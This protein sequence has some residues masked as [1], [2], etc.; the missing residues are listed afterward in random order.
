MN[1]CVFCE[2]VG[3]MTIISDNI[4]KEWEQR[5]EIFFDGTNCWDIVCYV[6]KE[7]ATTAERE[8]LEVVIGSIMSDR[9]ENINLDSD[10]DGLS[11]FL[12]NQFTTVRLLRKMTQIWMASAMERL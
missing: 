4:E 9:I 1:L 6:G 2:N 7:A 5:I 10:G 8:E 11:D 3:E 12:M